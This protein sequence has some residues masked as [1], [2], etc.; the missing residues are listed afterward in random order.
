MNYF[1]PYSPDF[2]FTMGIEEEYQIIDPETRELR[3]YIT[4]ILEQGRLE[5]HE[6]LKPEMMQSVVEVGTHVC[7]T[8]E[9]A[10]AEITRLR[11]AIAGLAA[12]QGLVIA[13][14]GTH[15]FSSW[16]TQ[17]IYPHERYY[18]VVNEMQDA[19]RQLLI[20]GMHVHVG[21]PDLELGVQIQNVARYFLPHLLCLSTSSPFWMGRQTGY[22]SYRS[23]VFGNF[24]RTGIPSQFS[25]LNEFQSYTDLLV[26]T[27]SIDNGKKI[28]WDIRPHPVFGTIEVRICDLCTKVDETI[29]IAALI[30]AIFVKI[31]KLFTCN[32]TF[33]VYRRALINENKWRAMRY[34]LNGELIDFGKQQ[35]M[36]ARDLLVEL[37]EF[38]DDVVDDLGSRQAVEYVHRMLE[39]GTSADRQ[40]ATYASTGDLKAVVDQLVRETVEGV[41]IEGVSIR[42]ATA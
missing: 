11:G 24:P 35:S 26:K 2:P 29:A 32:M 8:A 20:F 23:L 12:K 18:G 25:S 14:A 34:G 37:V 1:D 19:A 36:A 21:M 31:Y 39:E 17:E 30:Q 28:W 4:Q 22:K 9:E 16:E 5:L 27:G 33:R 13:A 7:R 41:P 38:V 42:T 3:S 15:P 10:R 40:L 6:Q